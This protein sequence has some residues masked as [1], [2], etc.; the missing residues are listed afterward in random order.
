MNRDKN[1]NIKVLMAKIQKEI[2]KPFKERIQMGYVERRTE[3]TPAELSY[4]VRLFRVQFNSM[5]NNLLKSVS[6]PSGFSWKKV[7]ANGVSAEYQE[8]RDVDGNRTILYIHGGAFFVGSAAVYRKCTAAMAEQFHARVLSIDYRLA[9]EHAFPAALDDCI[10]A[11]KWLLSKNIRPEDIIIAGDS[12]GGTLCLSTLLKLKQD[13]LP[14]PRAAICFSPATDFTYSGASW[15]SNAK[16]DPIIRFIPSSCYIISVMYAGNAE[17]TNPLVSPLFG[18]YRGL[19][20]ILI[21]VSKNEMLYSDATRVAEKAKKD[22]VNVTLQ[23]WEGMIHVFQ[24]FGIGTNWPEVFDAL[25]KVKTF[26][27]EVF[28]GEPPQT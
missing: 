28:Q 4:A 3:L 24:C 20:P 15:T 7:D 17:P 8:P 11:Y 12:A 5:I 26:I 27:D 25:S 2:S 1:V 13:G 16:T 10:M 14:E 21:Q 23:E 9:P 18:N 19:P 6:I 22:G